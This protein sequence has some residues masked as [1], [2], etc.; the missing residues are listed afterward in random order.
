MRANDE[1]AEAG[2]PGRETTLKRY[3]DWF[4]DNARWERFALRPGDIVISTP[5]KCG[6]TWM[7]TLC[8]MLVLNT[9]TFDQPLSRISPWLD[10]QLHD[11]GEVVAAGDQVAV[12]E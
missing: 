4:S 12:M 3:Q 11:I 1:P 7:Q 9:E 8:V 5:A 6:T 2:A 10:M